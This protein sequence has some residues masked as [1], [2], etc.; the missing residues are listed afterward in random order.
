MC[1]V[2]LTGAAVLGTLCL[3]ISAFAPAAAEPTALASGLREL[4]AAYDGGDPR[5]A[6]RLA[7]HIT[8]AAGDPLV[9]VHLKPGADANATLKQLADV[10]FQLT[11]RSSINPSLIEGYLPLAAVHA[12]TAVAGI[13]ALHAQ[14]RPVKHQALLPVLPPVKQAAVFEKANL[15][16]A[17][18]ITGKGIRIGAL[19]DSFDACPDPLCTDINGN[20]DH[21]AQDV[22]SGAL[23]AAGVTVLQ[24]FN[25]NLNPGRTPTDEGRA[26]LQLVHDIAPDAQLGFA[27]ADNGELSFAENILALRAQFNADVICDDVS[28]SDEPMY[29]DGILAQAVD[30]VSQAGAAYFSSAGNNGLEAYESVYHPIS[31]ARAQHVV[32]HGHGNVHLEQIPAAIR[33]LTVHNFNGGEDDGSPSITQR[34]SSRFNQGITFQWDEPF[35]LGLV[36]TNYI[37]YVFDKDGNWMD[38]NS[39]AFPGFYTT[40]N[41]L[42]TDTPNQFLFLPPFPTDFVGGVNV[43]DYQLVIGRT[44]DGPARHIKYININGL[45]VSERQNAPSTWGHSAARGGR[46]V[47]AQ[48]Y[49][50]PN[51]PEDFSSPGPV[52][53]YLDTAGNRLD[54]PEV[55]S[56]PQ[57]TAADGIDTTFFGGSDPDGDGYQNFFGT[58]AAAPDAA[59]VAGLVLQAAGG[60]GSLSPR[61]LYRRMEETAT[62]IPVPNMRWIAGAFA[63][64]LEFAVGGDWTRWDRDFSVEAEGIGHHSV[65]SIVMDISAI[66][67]V[68]DPNPNRFSVGDTTGPTIADI[69]PTVTG[70]GNTVLTMTFAPGTFTSGQSF[71]FGDRVFAPI[72]VTTQVDPDR[73]R[74]MKVTMTLDDGRHWTAPVVTLPKSPINN[75]TGFGLVNAD[76]ATR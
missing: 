26:M 62:P 36:K 39:P 54:E 19:S 3:L 8:N 10:G 15:A 53:I 31:F 13:R 41:A 63:G 12:A 2:R 75:S 55:R 42:L 72:Q 51:F 46:G 65:A 52:T 9:L 32:A 57:L 5:L 67:L 35:F 20:P 6:T 74:G 24:E 27:S 25:P 22:A 43:T 37:V 69:T 33:P 44:N 38:P 17:R 1:T 30:L 70:P 68:F 76:A 71:D 21:A 50:I 58:S 28:Y 49:A 7:M 47:A 61:R 59:A 66:G 29:S 60:P 64:P 73:F 56:T 34:F 11:T 48:Y 45:G 16:N 18:G 40:D 23:P 14:Q 4:A